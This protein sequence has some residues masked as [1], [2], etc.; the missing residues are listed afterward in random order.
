MYYK[1]FLFKYDKVPNLTLWSWHRSDDLL[2][3]DNN[4]AIASLIATIY[5]DL[6][7]IKLYQEQILL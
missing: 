2:F 3:I 5:I 7:K 1:V 6:D 4:T